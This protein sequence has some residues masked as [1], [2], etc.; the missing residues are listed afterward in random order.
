MYISEQYQLFYSVI[1]GYFVN[2][3]FQ[4]SNDSKGGYYG[5]GMVYARQGLQVLL[6]YQS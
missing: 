4:D 6:H 2:I 1:N 3:A 5:R